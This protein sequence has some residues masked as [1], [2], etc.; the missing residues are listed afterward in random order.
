MSVD[1]IRANEDLI[2]RLATEIADDAAR[3]DIET[4]CVAYTDDGRDPQGVVEIRNQ[5]Y[6]CGGLEEDIRALVNKSARYLALRGKLE[7][8]P[9]HQ[10]WVRIHD[11]R[12]V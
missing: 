8:H 9:K 3:A 11:P 6:D 10:T 5:W 1:T 12:S 7:Y 4:N 2:R